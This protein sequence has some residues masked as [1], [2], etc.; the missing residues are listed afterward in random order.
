[1]GLNESSN[2]KRTY[3]NIVGGKFAKRVDA[4]TP[5]AI[6]REIEYEGVKRMIHELHYKS[7]DAFIKGIEIKE[8]GKFGDQLLLNMDD[9]GDGF[10]V[11]LGINSREAKGFMQCLPNIDLTKYVTLEPYNYERK[12]DGKK[13]IGMGVKQDT[14]NVKYFYDEHSGFPNLGEEQV[15]KDE[16][17]LL[18]K[19]QTIF[20][21]KK[22]KAFIAEHFV[23]PSNVSTP[24]KI[25]PNTSVEAS[26]P[27]EYPN[28]MPF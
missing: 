11:T 18:M 12:K 4:T 5:N 13:M 22:T 2:E 3:L 10:T 16:F 20:L 17:E 19:Q 23:T 21:K 25:T 7:L 15:G 14:E 24:G 28:D 9:V 27:S 8:G 1:M 26:Q 6:E